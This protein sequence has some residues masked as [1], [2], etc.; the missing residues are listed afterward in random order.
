MI[1]VRMRLVILILSKLRCQCS[2]ELPLPPLVDCELVLAF[3][4]AAP[5]VSLSVVPVYDHHH[6]KLTSLPCTEGQ[7]RGPRQLSD[8]H[9][10]LGP[11]YH[12]VNA[13]V[14]PYMGTTHAAEALI[15]CTQGISRQAPLMPSSQPHFAHICSSCSRKQRCFLPRQRARLPGCLPANDAQRTKPGDQGNSGGFWQ[16]E[17]LT[18]K[19]NVLM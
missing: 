9:K 18:A 1:T 4:V 15:Y 8:L 6:T 11:C 2:C 10:A 14:T 16:Q 12:A 17:T 7:S 13:C 5:M 19:L 3:F